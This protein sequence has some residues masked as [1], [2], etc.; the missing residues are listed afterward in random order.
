MGAILRVVGAARSPWN[1][2]SW[3]ALAGFILR[4]GVNAGATCMPGPE[5]KSFRV[6]G[7]QRA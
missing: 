1:L 3:Q 4:D 5:M 7:A 2:T 6:A